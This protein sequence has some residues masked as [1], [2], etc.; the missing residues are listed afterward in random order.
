MWADEP[1]D[2]RRE[3]KCVVVDNNLLI[4]YDV[5]VYSLLNGYIRAQ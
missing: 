1:L 4:V 5:P 2:A 3:N